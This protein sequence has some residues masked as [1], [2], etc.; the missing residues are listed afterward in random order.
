MSVVPTSTILDS[1]ILIDYLNAIPQARTFVDGLSDPCISVITVSEVLV[2]VSTPQHAP[3]W[4]F[5]Q[6]FPILPIDTAIAIE[7]VHLR[8]Q[9]RWKLPDALQAALATHHGIT[10]A[11]RNHKDFNPASFPNVLLPYTI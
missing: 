7:A 10:L 8:R 6:T 1:V 3:T 9:H 5:L 2:G 4:A 11:T